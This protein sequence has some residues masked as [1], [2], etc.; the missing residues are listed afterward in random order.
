MMGDLHF[1]LRKTGKRVIVAVPGSSKGTAL[2]ND[3]KLVPPSP[4]ELYQKAHDLGFRITFETREI[5][6]EVAG[7][8][9]TLEEKP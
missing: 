7:R 8:F 1:R 4:Q 9:V 6:D 5:M 2:L 3:Y